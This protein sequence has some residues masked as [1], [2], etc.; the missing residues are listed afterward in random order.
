MQ[1]R[2]A[3]ALPLFERACKLVEGSQRDT[4]QHAVCL[5]NL[6]D[7]NNEL[8][9]HAQSLAL[10][11]RALAIRER[12]AGR[13]HPETAKVRMNMAL[14]LT[15]MGRDDE[16]LPIYR[17]AH[18]VLARALGDA[19]PITQEAKARLARADAQR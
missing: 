7:A 4:I 11:E 9:R 17:E 14:V 8:G 16:A 3:E 5:E 10:Y 19:H 15:A 13:E 6:A 12:R 18:D 1:G 2:T